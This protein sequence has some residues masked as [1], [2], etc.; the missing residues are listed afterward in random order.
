[1]KKHMALFLSVVFLI[2]ILC[3]CKNSDK[4]DTSQQGTNF[5]ETATDSNVTC[6]STEL[7]ETTEPIHSPLYLPD[8]TA[9]EIIDYFEEVVLHME[10]SDGE[11]NTALVQKWNIP[12]C[13]RIYGN[14]T[15]K[16]L[17]VLDDLFVKLNNVEG[18]PGIYVASDGEQEN[19]SIYFSEPDAFSEIFSAVIGDE[20]SYGAT[21]FWYYTDTND[22]YTANVGYRTDISQEERN[23]VLLEEIIN[24]LG[25][26]DTV[27]RED[28][29]VYQY[30][31][32]NTSLSDVDW[33]IVKLLYS[34]S[35]ECGS[36]LERCKAGIIKLY[37]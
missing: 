4:T 36:D 34:T 13:Y 6:E 3:A 29:I 1:M 20:D 23:S 17:A 10:Y 27:I 11:G 18:F 25:I 30:S 31:N 32:V 8:Y 35:I 28:S 37:Y 26:T 2:L 14:P 15:E 19:M 16:D 7:H 24:A 12:I 33:L 5:S 9:E 22:I 21:Q